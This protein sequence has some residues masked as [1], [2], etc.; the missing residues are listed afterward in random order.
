MN[1]DDIGPTDLVIGPAKDRRHEVEIALEI[2]PGH[3][4]AAPDVPQDPRDPRTVAHLLGHVLPRLALNE[5][6]RFR[7]STEDESPYWAVTGR[8][9]LWPPLFDALVDT[10]RMH[11]DLPSSALPRPEEPEIMKQA[12]IKGAV[13]LAGETKL[14]LGND[15]L[16]PLALLKIDP[17]THNIVSLEYVPNS[18]RAEGEEV[19]ECDGI[20]HLARALPG[21]HRLGT[22]NSGFAQDTATLLKSFGVRPYQIVRDNIGNAVGSKRPRKLNLSWRRHGGRIHISVNGGQFN[23]V[24]VDERILHSPVRS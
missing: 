21:L 7:R 2:G 18:E 6:R 9:A 23:D 22:L 15:L 1:V 13:Y 12:V 4:S 11:S 19:I 24:A 16:H 5:A 17:I 8:A 20:F 3:F 14:S 10:I